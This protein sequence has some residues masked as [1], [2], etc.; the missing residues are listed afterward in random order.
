[1]SFFGRFS[2]REIMA[3]YSGQSYLRDHWR[4]EV[5]KLPPSPWN[6]C[7]ELYNWNDEELVLDSIH[8][9]WAKMAFAGKTPEYWKRLVCGPGE[10]VFLPHRLYVATH[11]S[12]RPIKVSGNE[13]DNMGKGLKYPSRPEEA[14]LRGFVPR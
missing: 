9:E 2:I 10:W 3:R 1:M 14:K 7:I 12:G 4:K 8:P 6:V 11:A 13:G 5:G